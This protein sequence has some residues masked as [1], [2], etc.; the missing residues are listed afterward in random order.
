MIVQPCTYVFPY[1]G[2]TWPWDDGWEWNPPQDEGIQMNRGYLVPDTSAL[3]RP[4]EL[5]F[6][7]DND[8]YKT[9]RSHVTLGADFDPERRILLGDPIGTIEDDG[10]ITFFD[11]PFVT[12]WDTMEPMV[13]RFDDPGGVGAPTMLVRGYPG[14]STPRLWINFRNAANEYR[15]AYVDLGDHPRDETWYEWSEIPLP[16]DFPSD[17]ARAGGYETT[18]VFT[19]HGGI[20]S[21]YFSHL[22]FQYALDFTISGQLRDVDRRFTD[23]HL[24][25][26]EW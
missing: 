23:V 1:D 25:R 15:A 19:I 5:D 12:H 13:V 20:Y 24:N 6:M 3:S 16:A 17:A 26:R 7:W 18:V 14:G 21:G 11:D 2:V 22:A 9:N 8:G 4:G 10:S